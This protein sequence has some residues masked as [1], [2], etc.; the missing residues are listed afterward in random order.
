[1]KNFIR[2]SIHG[3]VCQALI[4]EFCS[5]SPEDYLVAFDANSL[6]GSVMADP[7]LLYPDV[8]TAEIAP[9]G[10]TFEELNKY[11]HYIA[12]LDMFTPNHLQKVPLPSKNIASPFDGKVVEGCMYVHGWSR[13]QTYN[14]VDI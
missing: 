13:Q 2:K 12:T 3:G 6:Y 10:I 1:M 11:P 9:K 8:N 4:P 7:N 14:S 5:V